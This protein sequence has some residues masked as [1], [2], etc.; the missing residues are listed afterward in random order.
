M[1]TAKDIAAEIRKTIKAA[2]KTGQ[3][4]ADWKISVRIELASMM[5][6]VNVTVTNIT[7]DQ[8]FTGTDD[9]R[10]WSDLA[11]DL[12]DQLHALIAPWGNWHNGRHNFLSIYYIGG[13]C[14]P[15]P[16][17]TAPKLVESTDHT[18][19]AL[20]FFLDGPHGRLECKITLD[21]A[22][23]VYPVEP[24]EEYGDAEIMQGDEICSMWRASGHDDAVVWSMLRDHYA[25]LNA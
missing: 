22:A 8:L 3:L 21:Y 23:V 4:S 11:R 24:G 17:P 10:E 2:Q 5:Q 14:A 13:L 19:D 12:S 15:N 16:R 6:A 20:R 7:E 9:D 25:G 18:G 1:T